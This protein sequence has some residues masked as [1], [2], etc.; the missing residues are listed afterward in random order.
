MPSVLAPEDIRSD[1]DTFSEGP[2]V[3]LDPSALSLLPGDVTVLTQFVQFIRRD[4]LQEHIP[5]SR[6]EIRGSVDPE[7]DTS[8][9]V[10]RVWIRGLADGEIRRYHYDLGERVDDWTAHLSEAQRQHFIARISFQ[11]RREADA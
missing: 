3:L 2:S 7:D 8:Q 4:V 1:A 6:I 9:I 5:A 10:V 11:A